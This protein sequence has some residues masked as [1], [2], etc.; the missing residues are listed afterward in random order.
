[1]AKNIR[2]LWPFAVTD[3]F[4][5]NQQT[6]LLEFTRAFL[7]RR[8]DLRCWTIRK[9]FFDIYPEFEDDVPVYE[10]SLG[11]VKPP[12]SNTSCGAARL[13]NWDDVTSRRRLSGGYGMAGEASDREE[14]E[15]RQVGGTSQEKVTLQRACNTWKGM[16]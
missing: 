11:L 10:P 9:D 12:S 5:P 4:A 3:A 7:D 13:A 14:D 16:S 1:L 15:Q 8:D 6:G 2:F